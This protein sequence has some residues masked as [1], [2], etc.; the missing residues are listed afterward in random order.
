MPGLDILAL[1][2]AWGEGFPNVIGEALACQ[3]P[4]VATDVGDSALIVGD[5]GVIVPPGDA[6]AFAN[7]LVKMSELGPQGR[8]ALG[9][10]GRNRGKENYGLKEI[11]ARYDKLHSDLIEAKNASVM[12]FALQDDNASMLR[13]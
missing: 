4:V 11:S 12:K 13:P 1:A 8:K 2:S 7:A 10:A 3:V 6:E 5:S 9:F